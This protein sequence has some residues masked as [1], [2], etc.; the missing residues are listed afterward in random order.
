MQD[1]QAIFIFELSRNG[2]GKKNS[3]PDFTR[4]D[5]ETR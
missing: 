2:F 1:I 4:I 5:K 3:Y